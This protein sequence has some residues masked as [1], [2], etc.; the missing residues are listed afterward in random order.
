MHWLLGVSVPEAY[1]R[2][3]TFSALISIHPAAPYVC[4]L[5]RPFF[6]LP[7]LGEKR[8]EWKWIFR[9]WHSHPHDEQHYYFFRMRRQ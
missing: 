3:L 8:K 1:C 9:I 4:R 5:R 2:I 7:M 6:L